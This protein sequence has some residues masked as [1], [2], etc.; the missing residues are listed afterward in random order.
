[1][2]MYYVYI[3]T[4]RTGS[5][6]VGVTNNLM[7]RVLE[8]KQHLVPGFTSKYKIDRL[9]WYEATPDIRAAIAREKRI[10]GWLRKKKLALIT[11]KNPM[12]RDLSAAWFE[13]DGA[14]NL[15]S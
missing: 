13:G 2:R 1:M 8:H 10:K 11:A 4:N 15:S 7:R 14:G 12:W 9:V 5:L 3:L 6:Y